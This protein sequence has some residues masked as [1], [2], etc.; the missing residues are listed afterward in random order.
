MISKAKRTFTLQQDES[1]CGVACLLSAIRYLEGNNNLENLRKLSGTDVF[2]TTLLG[3]TQCA[4]A[5]GITAEGF[6]AEVEHLFDLK[7]LS[8]LHLTL[9]N[10]LEHFVLN[11]GYN[12]LSQKFL[13][14]DPATGV[15]YW[16][17][18]ELQKV[19]KS[20]V[21][22]TLEP[23]HSFIKAKI[24][25]NAKKKWLFFLLKDDINILL[26]ATF[27][28][29]VIAGLGL[30]TAIFIQKLVDEIIPKQEIKRMFSGFLI[31]FTL[32]LAKSSI[33][34]IRQLFLLQQAKDFNERINSSFVEKL[35]RLPKLFFD[36]RKTGDLIARLNDTMRIQKSIAYLSSTFV[37]DFLVI[38]ISSVYLFSF[39]YAIALTALTSIPLMGFCAWKY[40][41][42]IITQNTNV[43]TA[44]SA[45]ESNYIDA[46]QGI[47]VIKSHGKENQYAQK[48][49]SFFSQFQSNSN[50]LGKTGNSFNLIVDVLATVIIIT[51]MA[52]TA[53]LTLEKTLKTG[54]M[55]AILSIGIGIIPSCT[56]LMLTNLQIQEAKV[57]YNRM[58]EFTSIEPEKST[59]AS[60]EWNNPFE[61]LEIKNLSF[62]FAGRSL[63]LKNINLSVNKG[64]ITALIGES[65][66]GK[67]TIFQ[68]LQKFYLYETGDILINNYINLMDLPTKNWRDVI[69]VVPQD[70]KLFNCSIIENICLSNREDDLK[71]VIDLCEQHDLGNYFNQFPSGIFTKVGEDGLNLSGG[72]KQIVAL[73]R[74]LFNK[75]QLLLLD[76]ATAALDPKTETFILNL[77][78]K[79]KEQMGILLVTHKESTINIADDVYEIENGISKHLNLSI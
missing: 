71:L 4:E 55:M 32:L 31:L 37:I 23:N 66:C 3:L 53:Y 77:L 78:I 16:D 21:L 74:A 58:Y 36:S 60:H 5:V 39:H 12:N 79:L 62:R 45:N 2:G 28:G 11:Y 75:P 13:I 38:V 48:I 34:F 10:G 57:A 24:E 26:T 17:N 29:I 18:S 73:L 22:L 52:E 44:Y 8:L 51:I 19:W 1:D 67:S 27:L 54:E 15:S 72:Q 50:I 40:N 43:M 56:R 65:G 63:L 76:E 47:D 68:V 46:I 64:S 20:K 6:E 14:G 7:Q 59:L 35:L 69:A 41:A 33:S 70:I 49:R 25:N 61:K 9:E 30:S 42:K